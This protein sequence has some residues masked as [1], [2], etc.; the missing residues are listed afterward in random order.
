MDLSI[1]G[2]MA[3]PVPPNASISIPENEDL[4]EE[5]IYQLLKD[6]GQRLGSTLRSPSRTSSLQ[7]QLAMSSLQERY[8]I[9]SYFQFLV[10]L[11]ICLSY[12][13]MF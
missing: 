10:I 7:N 4:S 9:S 1:S 2:D 6:A 8:W 12:Q 11:V 5:Q 13:S 3:D